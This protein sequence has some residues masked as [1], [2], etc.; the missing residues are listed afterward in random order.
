M[1]HHIG[2]SLRLDPRHP[3]LWRTPTSAQLGIDPAA[4][5]LDDVTETQ[6]RLLA[7][8]AVGV[9]RPG[10]TMIARGRSD[11]IDPLLELVAP[12]LADDARP[13]VHTVAVTGVGTLA[14]LLAHCLADS[15][16]VIERAAD[17]VEL[18]GTPDLAVHVAVNVLPPALHGV[19]LRRDVP[20]L[21]IVVGEHAATVGPIVEPGTGACLLCVELHRRDADPAWPALAT[22]LLGRPV[23][24]DDAVLRLESAALACRLVLERLAG[25]AGPAVSTRIDA[26]TGGGQ[27]TTWS[28][29]PDC[30][31]RGIDALPTL[32]RVPESV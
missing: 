4:A 24:T 23:T 17:P 29:H 22:Q 18:E 15:G 19:W 31:C 26:V 30:G 3:L 2:M 10:L 25:S 21:A 7:A 14:D 16:V 11:E 27:Q 6:E 8:L 32:L 5:V 12:A 9:S 13:P 28:Q 1:G 20:H